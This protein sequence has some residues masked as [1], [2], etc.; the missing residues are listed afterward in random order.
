MTCS[1][2]FMTYFRPSLFVLLSL[3]TSAW[4]SHMGILADMED[5]S[6][7]PGLYLLGPDMRQA[8]YCAYPSMSF[9][10]IET[11][12]TRYFR[13]LPTDTEHIPSEALQ[14]TWGDVAYVAATA[15]PNPERFCGIPSTA[16][17]GTWGDTG[18]APP[19]LEGAHDGEELHS[20]RT[21]ASLNPD[22][23]Y[24]TIM[25]LHAILYRP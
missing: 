6:R 18:H 14:G 7:L 1:F 2:F 20:A 16:L 24:A 11:A 13:S 9:E 21:L 10:N 19:S 12:L 23:P 15:T 3:I 25:D 17:H 5:F 8:F 22:I 4:S